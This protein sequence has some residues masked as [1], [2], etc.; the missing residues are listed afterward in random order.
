MIAAAAA[1]HDT[2]GEDGE[3]NKKRGNILLLSRSC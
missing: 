1:V 3:E 2:L